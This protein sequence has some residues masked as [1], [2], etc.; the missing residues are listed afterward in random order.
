MDWNLFYDLARQVAKKVNNSGYKPDMIVGLARGGWVLARVLCDLIGVKDLVSLK[1]EHWGVTA[2]P[3]GKAK[4]K[5]PLNVDLTEKN[6]LVVDD[7]TDTGESMHV[8]VEYLKSLK[9]SEI[10]TA[11]L[12]HITSSKFM[13]DYF[14]EE[15][16]WRWVIFP[17]NFTEDLCNIVPKVCARLKMSPDGD[18]DV[19]QIRNELK[20]F[21]TIDTTEETVAD[22]LEELKRRNLIQGNTKK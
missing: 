22:I 5:Y 21:Y 8:T 18:V 2:T 15:I 10:K 20:Q 13:P 11:A 17:W 6:V 19:T 14:G 4:L 16:S 9:P 12:R 3:D 7:I 1:V